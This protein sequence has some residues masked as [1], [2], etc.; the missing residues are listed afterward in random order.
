MINIFNIVLYQPLLNLLVFFYN[1]IPYHDIGI[2]IILLT[3]VIRLLLFPLTLKSLKVQKGM[4]ELQPKI[5]ELKKKYKDQKDIMSQELMK[6]YKEEKVSPFSSCLPILL[7]IPILW[8]LFKVFNT[9]L[10]SD[11]LTGIYSF[12]ANPGALNHVSFGFFDLSRPDYVLAALAALAQFFQSKMMP[13]KRPEVKGEGSKD[14][15]MA[16]VM[17][18]QMMYFMPV[19]TF[20][21][22]VTLPGGLS[23]YWLLSTLT[24]L[25]QQWYFLRNHKAQNTEHGA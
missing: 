10:K 4:Q 11:A 16:A 13:M 1:I 21:I 14:E 17:N 22:G 9:G 25:L 6:L 12:I 15:D 5:E 20:I 2:S 3:L 19:M 7:Q 8:A 18:K 24:M 23:L